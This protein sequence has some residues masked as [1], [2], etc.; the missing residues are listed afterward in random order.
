[1][2]ILTNVVF[3]VLIVVAPTAQGRE[4]DLRQH[5]RLYLEFVLHV[6]SIP[7]CNSSTTIQG[8]LYQKVLGQV[9]QTETRQ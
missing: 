4:A 7:T 3:F 5:T 9:C 8:S 1:M 6:R 2:N